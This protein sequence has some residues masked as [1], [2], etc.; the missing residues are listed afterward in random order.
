[1]PFGLPY[2]IPSGL[3]SDSIL[4]GGIPAG[5]GSSGGIPSGGGSS[6]GIPS[7][8]IPSGGIPSGGIPSGGIPSG[9]IPSGGGS[10][11]G[12]SSGGG[13][14]G[15]G[16]SSG[17]GSS[18]G[19]SSGLP[20]G[21]SSGIL[22][23]VTSNIPSGLSSSILSGVNSNIPS[24]LSSSIISGISSSLPASIPVNIP[25]ST[26]VSTPSSNNT[27][28]DSLE[29]LLSDIK[30]LQNIEKELFDTLET[31]T[32]LTSEQYN[33][34]ILKINSISQMRVNLYQTLGNINIFYKDGVLHSQ[35]VLEQQVFAIGIVEKQLNEIKQKLQYLELQKNNKIRLIE[36]NDYYGQKYSEHAL[37]MKYIIFTLVP[38]I[39]ISFLY[40]K[41]FLPKFIFYI[42]LII[43]TVIGSIFIIFRLVSIW[44]RDNMNYQSYLWSF[45]IKNAPSVISNAGNANDPWLSSGN[46]LG[47]CM[48]SNGSIQ[49]TGTSSKESF[50]NNVFTK[51]S[52]V[53]KKADIIIDNEVMPS[54]YY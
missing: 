45:N 50:V 24:G 21:V 54:N 7:G 1:M 30:S 35:E 36:I 12:G 19:G 17:G 52:N 48:N 39:I 41:G 2:N 13:G 6:G 53:N 51:N 33:K 22:S 37:L 47:M 9:G 15:G 29:K 43:I 38:I 8:S 4:S 11:G 49:T 25:V 27:S 14:G 23:G 32:N 26:P 18:S 5:G 10:S 20:S 46:N 28:I 3:S 16:G 31:V 40:N 34:I 44:N 42:L